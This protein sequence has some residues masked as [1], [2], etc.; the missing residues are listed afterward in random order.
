MRWFLKDVM[1]GWLVGTGVAYLHYYYN[2]TFFES[3]VSIV[4]FVVAYLYFISK[5]R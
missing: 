5:S 3:N 2:L 1:I 4:F